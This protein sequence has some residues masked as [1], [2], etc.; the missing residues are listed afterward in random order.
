LFWYNPL[1][2]QCFIGENSSKW[3]ICRVILWHCQYL[4]YIASKGRITDELERIWKEVVV[5]A[6][7]RY[8][9][10]ICLKVLRKAIKKKNW[11]DSQSPGQDLNQSPPRYM[12]RLLL[13]HQAVCDQISHSLLPSIPSFP[14]P[15]VCPRFSFE[16]Y[17]HPMY[18]SS[19]N[20]VCLLL[21]RNSSLLF[22]IFQLTAYSSM[23]YCKQIH[24]DHH[25]AHRK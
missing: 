1:P 10:N 13:P 20:Y 14:L 19:E 6:S 4:H 2:T 15:K 8:Y 16:K 3:N 17:G 7:V 18:K 5:M 9:P 12:S 23:W 25:S 21:C 11:E 22:C 24:E